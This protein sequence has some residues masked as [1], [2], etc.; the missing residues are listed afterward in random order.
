MQWFKD[1]KIVHKI[2]LLVAIASFFT[3]TV[4][5]VGYTISLKADKKLASMY[6]NNLLSVQ[7][8]NTC[9]S[10]INA[11]KANAFELILNTDPEKKEKILKDI[12]RRIAEVVEMMA[13]VEKHI[14]KSEFNEF[15]KVQNDL[16]EY[17]EVRKTL[18]NLAI[19]GRKK[20]AYQY[21]LDN[22]NI[23][24]DVQASLR[25]FAHLQ[26]EKA[27]ELNEKNHNDL[28]YASFIMLA[29]VLSSIILTSVIGICVA[30]VIHKGM[31]LVITNMKDV[32]AG[33]LRIDSI[34]VTCKSEIGQLS[35]AFNQM[36][37]NLRNLVREVSSASSDVSASSQEMHAASEMT[38]QATQHIAKG[39]EQIAVGASE[40]AQGIAESVSNLEEINSSIQNVLKNVENTMTISKE[41]EA[42]AN[43]GSCKANIAVD[44]S[45]QVKDSTI[46]IS[47]V[48]NELGKL[49][50]E[51]E[52]I[53]DLIKGIAGQTNLLALNAA[54]EAAR[55]GEHGKGFAVVA[56]EV[57]KLA[58]ESATATDKITGMIKDIQN[59]TVNAVN[60]MDKA[61]LEVDESVDLIMNVQESLKNIASAS[62]L[63]NKHIQEVS[64]KV[65]KLAVNSDNVVNT[66]ENLSSLTEEAAASTE[67]LSSMTEEQT[68]S[69]EEINASAKG[70]AAIAEKMNSLVAVFKV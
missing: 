34:K 11:N 18:V 68:A 4:G 16:I 12:D 37:I 5:L 22:E 63:T 56:E 19:E 64:S 54:I 8:L 31:E 23:F 24:N 67:E 38:A 35:D 13:Y 51:I 27:K 36:R 66:M 25:A 57:K 60:I 44:K 62:I 48:I 1:L 39:I 70:L 46:E 45:R 32:A 52:V 3:L 28:I 61:Q 58:T 49:G 53:V 20:E 59:K 17:K 69:M 2:L 50:S 7:W 43:D 40:Q 26:E 29:V 15:N 9:R 47:T 65:D 30:T 42:N 10:Y 21:Y 6:N 41:T 14:D 55:A 33:N